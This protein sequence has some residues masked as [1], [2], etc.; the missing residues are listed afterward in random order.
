VIRVKNISPDIII[1]KDY[2]RDMRL[3]FNYYKKGKGIKK[4]TVSHFMSQPNL[5][6]LLSKHKKQIERYEDKD[7]TTLPPPDIIK[8]LILILNLDPYKLFGLSKYET[9]EDILQ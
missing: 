1:D 2:L 8:K 7:C 3:S 6:R 4:N 9:D 5:A